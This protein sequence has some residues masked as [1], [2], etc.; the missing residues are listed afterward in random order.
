MAQKKLHQF[1]K[2]RYFAGLLLL[3]VAFSSYAMV[4]FIGSNADFIERF[5]A[6]VINGTGG[7]YVPSGDNPFSDLPAEHTNS[8]AIVSLYEMGILQG[9]ENGTF[10]P[11]A[12]VNRAEFA[13]ILAEA[14]GLDYAKYEA[15]DVANCFGDVTDLPGHWFAPYVCAAKNEGWV[16][17]YDGGVYGPGRDINKAEALKIILGALKFEIPDN[18]MVTEMPYSDVSA[19]DWYLGVAQAAKQNNIVGFSDLFVADE[20]VTRGSVAQMIYN[21][22]E[23]L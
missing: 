6:D 10:K 9:Y 18:A 8:T 11:D 23:N 3:F 7:S 21:A 5:Y 2:N 14:A 16:N 22:L 12:K 1:Y 20:L 17:G 15:S 4:S 19:N 13:K